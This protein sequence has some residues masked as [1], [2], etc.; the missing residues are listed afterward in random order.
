MLVKDCGR[1]LSVTVF[2]QPLIV[3][4]YVDELGIRKLLKEL[5]NQVSQLILLQCPWVLLAFSALRAPRAVPLSWHSWVLPTLRVQC[6][7]A[8][9]LLAH[10]CIHVNVSIPGWQS[11]VLTT[12]REAHVVLTPYQVWG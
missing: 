11:T 12:C 10:V 6:S 1:R 8:S 7:V 3:D 4:G 2:L 5:S 9:A